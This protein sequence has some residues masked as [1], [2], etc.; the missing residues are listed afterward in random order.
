VNDACYIVNPA[1]PAA[2]EQLPHSD[3]WR[4]MCNCLDENGRQTVT[5]ESGTQDEAARA[6]AEHRGEPV[7]ELE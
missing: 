4:S 7:G 3:K 2:V 6:L 1:S 5:C